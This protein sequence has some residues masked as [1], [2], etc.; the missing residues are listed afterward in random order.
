MTGFEAKVTF[1]TPVDYFKD[2]LSIASCE[3]EKTYGLP[4][5]DYWKAVNCKL[6]EIR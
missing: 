4:L 5:N 1:W 3:G 6:N 2:I